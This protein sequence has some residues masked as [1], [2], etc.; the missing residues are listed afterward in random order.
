[1]APL[2]LP[3]VPDVCRM[4]ATSSSPRCTGDSCAGK[5]AVSL[6]SPAS[7][8]TQHRARTSA[9]PA[10]ASG[11]KAGA[12]NNALAPLLDRE[13][14]TSRDLRRGFIG[15]APAPPYMTP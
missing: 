11:A 15:T 1:M 5:S 2:G 7:S 6:A 10:V 12:A 4:T 3:V 13:Y 14:D 9:A 8:T